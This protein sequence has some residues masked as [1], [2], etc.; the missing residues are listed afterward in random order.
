MK[1]RR[2]SQQSKE[3]ATD[4]EVDG[5]GGG[6]SLASLLYSHYASASSSHPRHVSSRVSPFLLEEVQTRACKRPIRGTAAGLLKRNGKE[7]TAGETAVNDDKEVGNG[8]AWQGLE[9]MSRM[10]VGSGLGF[11]VQGSQP[12]RKKKRK[13]ESRPPAATSPAPLEIKSTVISTTL[14][15]QPSQHKPALLTAYPS[16]LPRPDRK[17]PEQ[18]PSRPYPSTQ[19]QPQPHPT[20][21]HVWHQQLRGTRSLLSLEN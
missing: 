4:E 6:E 14:L 9:D 21:R 13:A 2:G 1:E 3:R 17:L 20:E 12:K 19:Q 16:I 5:G 15:P 11:L 7:K 18:P 8:P 10:G